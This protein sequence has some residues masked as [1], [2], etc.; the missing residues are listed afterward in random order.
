MRGAMIKFIKVTK[1]FPS[2]VAA[3]KDIGF[4]VDT[5]EMMLITGPSGSGK[6]TLLKLLIREY[7]PSSGQI[8]FQENLIN[9]IKE[10]KIPEHRRK[11]GVVFQDYKLLNEL[12]VWENI[13]LPLYIANKNETE[14][15]SR[16]TDLLKLVSLTSKALMFP[17][18]LSGGEAQR[19]GI[20]R[21]LAT[22]PKVVFADEPTGNLDPETS[23]NIIKLFKKINELGTTI[24]LATHDAMVLDNLANMRKIKLKNG[25]M[26]DDS[27]KKS[28]DKDRSKKTVHIKFESLDED[29]QD[30]K[31]TKGE[32]KKLNK[33][34]KN[35]KEKKT[36]TRVKL[37]KIKLN[38]KKTKQDKSED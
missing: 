11:I 32:D 15:E 14:I 8:F 33:N 16:V 7:M 1:T 38:L 35:D 28:T 4:E 27:G 17:S 18:Q 21:A 24:L 13:A 29:K 10:S 26:V 19:I 37:P 31:E 30:N 22:G 36:K 12:N 6:T 3:L 20:A 2:G 5:G 23:L 9:K 34:K 25:E